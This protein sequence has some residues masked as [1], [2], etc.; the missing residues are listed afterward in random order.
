MWDLPR[1]GIQ[2]V[3]PALAGGFLTTAPPGKSCENI[4]NESV[5]YL[6][7]SSILSSWAALP[8]LTC[9]LSL[10]DFPLNLPVW[11]EPPDDGS[12]AAQQWVE[13]PWRTGFA[14]T[15][16]AL[17]PT[18]PRQC[19]CTL[20]AATL[21]SH[22]EHKWF[23]VKWHIWQEQA[24]WRGFLKAPWRQVVGGSEVL[25]VGKFPAG[26][27]LPK[28]FV[29]TQFAHV[30]KNNELGRWG[31]VFSNLLSRGLW[32]MEYSQILPTMF[33]IPRSYPVHLWFWNGLH[34]N[35]LGKW[36]SAFLW[37]HL[38]SE[39][40][41]LPVVFHS[42]SFSIMSNPWSNHISK[43]M[44]LTSNM[45]TVIMSKHHGSKLWL[46]HGQQNRVSLGLVYIK[47]KKIMIC[48]KVNGQ[49]LPRGHCLEGLLRI[50]IEDEPLLVLFCRSYA[51]SLV[52]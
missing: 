44:K 48:Y 47:K 28:C 51:I 8:T 39:I 40:S 17:W 41:L 1:P 23:L 18:T 45:R 42:H 49:M 16:M 4:F 35:T 12:H 50:E 38:E 33:F 30:T 19:H 9:F 25:R 15:W 52:G 24:G 22:S 26:P 34:S 36:Y 2:P 10:W 14:V 31:G 29:S 27:P 32:C 11:E 7:L 21:A 37:R 13:K 46:F 6:G 20:S 5:S 3:S 43:V